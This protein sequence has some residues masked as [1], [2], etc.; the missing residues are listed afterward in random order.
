NLFMSQNRYDEAEN[1]YKTALL[2]NPSYFI[3][4]RNLALLF[5]KSQRYKESVE[6]YKIALEYKPEDIISWQNLGNVYHYLEDWRGSVVCWENAI[7]YGYKDST[8]NIR[9]NENKEKLYHSTKINQ[10]Q[11]EKQEQVIFKGIE[12]EIKEE[13]RKLSLIEELITLIKQFTN[14]VPIS[15]DRISKLLKIPEKQVE[16]YL[17]ELLVYQENLGD[18]LELEHIFIK[19]SQVEDN[20]EKVIQNT[21]SK[22]FSSLQECTNCNNTQ[23]VLIRECSNCSAIMPYCQICKR[24][25]TDKDTIRKCQHCNKQ[26][27]SVHIRAYIQSKGACPVCREGLNEKMLI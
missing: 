22:P 16:S 14:D 20:I 1:A 4:I 25:F 12:Q 7:K 11:K 24:G 21:N 2:Y 3:S 27:H 23:S 18:Y 10:I 17:K 13:E 8:L 15:L 6:M 5:Q 19:R 26:F 9:I